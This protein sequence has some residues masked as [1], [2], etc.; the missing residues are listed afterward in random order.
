MGFS[1]VPTSLFANSLSLASAV[2]ISEEE[3]SPRH[4]SVFISHW[5]GLSRPLK[6]KKLHLQLP[7]VHYCHVENDLL[8]I[9]E[10]FFSSLHCML[11][12]TQ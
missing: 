1:H 12:R 6:F 4:L 8:C 2:S 7:S 9:H 3:N 10:I 5:S 11:L